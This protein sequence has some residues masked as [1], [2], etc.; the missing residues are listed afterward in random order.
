MSSD[1][2]SFFSLGRT[3]RAAEFAKSEQEATEKPLES[4]DEREFAEET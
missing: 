3:S 4:L 2:R 1:R